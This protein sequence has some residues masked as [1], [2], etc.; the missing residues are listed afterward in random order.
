[1]KGKTHDMKQGTQFVQTRS[2]NKES[3][4]SKGIEVCFLAQMSIKKGIKTF[5]KRA[6][7][8][9]LKEY[10]QLDDMTVF[11]G[12][13]PSTMSKLEKSRA[14]RAINLINEKRCR[15]IKGR[16]FADGMPALRD[17]VSR[18][19]ASSPTI[20]LELLFASLIIDSH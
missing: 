8:A 9:M 5:G 12:Q 11:A 1:M 18:E 3:L 10:E 20:A 14:L 17:Y 19:E 6:V 4:H 2:I 7:T 15:K 13:D 16:T